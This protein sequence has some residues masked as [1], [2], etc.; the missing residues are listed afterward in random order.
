ML[1]GKITSQ[2][3]ELNEVYV[4]NL[5]SE[6]S[7]TT[8]NNGSFSMFVKVGDTLQFSGLQI[9]GK[10]RGLMKVILPKNYL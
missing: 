5:R 8:D 7:T 1:K 4:T 2:I 3:K 10:K 9:V 6:S